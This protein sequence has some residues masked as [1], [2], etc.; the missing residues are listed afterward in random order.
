MT[1]CYRSQL[2]LTA[3]QA[4][5][6]FHQIMAGVEQIHRISSPRLESCGAHLAACIL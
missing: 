6:F 5:R 1:S 4:C 3:A 2:S